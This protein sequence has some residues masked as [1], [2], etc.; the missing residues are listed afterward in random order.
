VDRDDIDAVASP[1]R[2]VCF[3][4]TIRYAYRTGSAPGVRRD[5]SR[6]IRAAGDSEAKASRSSRRRLRRHCRRR[7][8][9]LSRRRRRCRRHRRRPIN[10]A[11]S[12]RRRVDVGRFLT[13][14]G[15]M[16]FIDLLSLVE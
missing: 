9:R 12:T 15:D 2:L 8:R 6:Y 4:T 13:S 7:R 3:A 1:M 11:S 5:V 10:G 16:N 14:H